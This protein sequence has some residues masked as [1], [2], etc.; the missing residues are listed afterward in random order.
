MADLRLITLADFSTSRYQQVA[1]SIDGDITDIIAQAEEYVE[2]LVDRRFSETTYT[3]YHFPRSEEIFLRNRPIITL[4]S[5]ERRA[6][7]TDDWTSLDVDTFDIELDGKIGTIV[8][9]Y[10]DVAGY[11]LKVV[12][13]A[14]YAAIPAD[15][16]AAVILQTVIFAY[17]DL[18]VYGAGDAKK[19]GI[20]Y[21]QDQVDRYL[22]RYR[23]I[24]I[25]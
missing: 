9:R 25:A 10:S 8:T 13:T 14:G 24:K 3:E 20:T 22:C 12:Y 4:T 1:D 21:L 6:S 19:P 16:K 15:V 5:V 7:Y 23:Q 18:E 17:Q 11:E 2:G